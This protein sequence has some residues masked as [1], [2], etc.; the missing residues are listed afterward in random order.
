MS[1]NRRHIKNANAFVVSLLYGKKS[2]IYKM[3][4]FIEHL[5]IYR[6]KKIKREWLDKE[7]VE[8]EGEV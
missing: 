5:I 8:V 7:Y 3:K 6:D 2:V 4:I 1:I